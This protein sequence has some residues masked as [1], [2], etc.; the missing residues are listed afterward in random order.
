MKLFNPVKTTLAAL[1]LLFNVFNAYSQVPCAF[2]IQHRWQLKNNSFYKKA[3]A[4]ANKKAKTLLSDKDF[5]R[6]QAPVYRI[7]VVV[8]VVHNGEAVGTGSNISDAQIQ[9]AITSLTQYY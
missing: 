6:V 5:M 2:D 4:E 9:S 8:H 3:I 1:I 7:P